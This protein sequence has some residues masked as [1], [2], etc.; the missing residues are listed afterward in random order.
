[1]ASGLGI[2]RKSKHIEL[3]HLWVQDVLSEGI[4]SLESVGTHRNPSDVLTRCVQAAILGQHIPRLH[5]FKDPALSQV[6]KGL[7]VEGIKTFKSKKEDSI[8]KEDALQC[9]SCTFK[10][11]SKSLQSTPRSVQCSR[12]SLYACFRFF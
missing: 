9:K 12:S 4:I 10:S 5:L 6:C 2:S 11:I 3:K 8:V 1:M 7:G